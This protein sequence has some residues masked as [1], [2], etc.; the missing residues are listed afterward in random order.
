L[1]IDIRSAVGDTISV[2][3]LSLLIIVFISVFV[4][5]R[6]AI[7]HSGGTQA[8]SIINQG[9]FT[10]VSILGIVGVVGLIGLVL[11]VIR[12]FGYSQFEF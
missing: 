1:S 3:R 11:W 9:I 8:T 12:S 5:F 4:V 10:L 2:V 6:N 7:A